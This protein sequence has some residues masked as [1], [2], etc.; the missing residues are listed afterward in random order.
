MLRSTVR[1]FHDLRGYQEDVRWPGWQIIIGIET[2]AQI[3][4]RR[5]LF[6]G[7]YNHDSHQSCLDEILQSPCLQNQ[8]THPMHMF[9]YLTLPSLE[10]YRSVCGS[11]RLLV[12]VLK[13]NRGSTQNASTWRFV[14]LWH[15]GVI[16]LGGPHSIESITSTQTCQLVIKL[17]NS[18]V[19][20]FLPHVPS[21]LTFKS[22]PLA[23]HGELEIHCSGSVPI[24]IRIK[25]IQLEQVR[26]L[27][28]PGLAHDSTLV[29]GYGQVNLQPPQPHI[30][31]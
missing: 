5:K 3:K 9:L 23:R 4:S 2:H 6:S 25:Q 27:H 7:Q 19:S 11:F 12:S 28:Y 26:M 24:K 16:Y 10:R 29:T 8:T 13:L 14:R 15:L 20:S 18:T 1:A 17:P 30:P 21:Y 22:A 31:Y